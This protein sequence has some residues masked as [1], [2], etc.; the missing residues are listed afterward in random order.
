MSQFQGQLESKTR[1]LES[2]SSKLKTAEKN[3]ENLENERLPMSAPSF[4][5]PQKRESFK[6][7]KSFAGKCVCTA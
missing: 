2:V 3:V 5:T 1:D 7:N 4:A 6:S